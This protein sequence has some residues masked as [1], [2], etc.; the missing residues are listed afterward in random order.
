MKKYYIVKNNEQNGPFSLDEILSS[1]IKSNSLIWFEGMQNWERAE[2]IDELKIL[3]RSMPPPIP[4]V[5]EEKVY[6]V[7]AELTKKKKKEKLIKPETEIMAAKEIMFNLKLIGFA[8]IIGILSFPLHFELKDGFKHNTMLR[9]WENLFRIK[10]ETPEESGKWVSEFYKLIRESNRLG[11]KGDSYS[12]SLRSFHESKI[13]LATKDSIWP[14]IL[15]AIISG[16]VLIVGRY[17]IKVA[18]WVIYTSKK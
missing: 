7:E 11:A 6:K 18:K 9:K 16:I 15:T 12:S 17:L 10:T 5:Q 2:N 8:L 3:F 4:K 13:E 14:S 1:D